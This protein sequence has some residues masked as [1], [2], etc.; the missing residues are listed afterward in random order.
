MTYEQQNQVWAAKKFIE[1]GWTIEKVLSNK[2]KF[3]YFIT[4][5]NWLGY[6]NGSG[7]SYRDHRNG[8]YKDGVLLINHHHVDD[9][10]YIEI[11]SD[12]NAEYIYGDNDPRYSGNPH[13]KLKG[14]EWITVWDFGKVVKDGPWWPEIHK[15]IQYWIDTAI[16]KSNTLIEWAEKEKE[17]ISKEKLDREAAVVQSWS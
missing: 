3:C 9:I 1:E 12:K 17:R 2:S 8:V 6:K 14:A 13:P 16:S 4:C 10:C 5:L 15:V 7:S 11:A